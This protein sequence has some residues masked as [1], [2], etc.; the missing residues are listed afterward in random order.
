VV[1]KTCSPYVFFRPTV[2][3][4][5][6]VD[7]PGKPAGIVRLAFSAISQRFLGGIFGIFGR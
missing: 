4:L 2:C 1:I 7:A 5:Y 3:A 6:P